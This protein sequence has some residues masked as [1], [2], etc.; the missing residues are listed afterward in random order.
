MEELGGLGIPEA[1]FEKRRLNNEKK[2]GEEVEEVK[3]QLSGMRDLRAFQSKRSWGRKRR[4]MG[5]VRE[6]VMKV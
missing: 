6:C 2:K 4:R 5:E 3:R 1:E